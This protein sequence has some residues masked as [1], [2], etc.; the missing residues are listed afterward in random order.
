MGDWAYIWNR[1]WHGEAIVSPNGVG[2]DDFVAVAVVV[3]L[4]HDRKIL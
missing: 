2:A 3:A 1:N 4:R